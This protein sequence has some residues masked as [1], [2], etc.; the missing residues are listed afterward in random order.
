MVAQVSSPQVIHDEVE[1]VV[2]LEGALH[3][4]EEGV[5]EEAEDPA[6]VEHG[7]D[8]ILLDDSR[9]QGGYFLLEI[10]FIA[11]SFMLSLLA[12]FHTL[13]NPPNPI[14]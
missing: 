6:L 1:V 10:S 13:P 8:V 3:V 7:F 9:Y 5:G 2:V 4:D 12:T 14:W 11:Q